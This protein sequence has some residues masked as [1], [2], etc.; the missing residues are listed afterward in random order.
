MYGRTNRLGDAFYGQITLNF[1]LIKPGTF[2]IRFHV[3]M[4]CSDA[5]GCDQAGDT[6]QVMVNNESPIGFQV[7]IDYDNIGQQRVWQKI[8]SLFTTSQNDLEV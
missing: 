7:N 5:S 1:D 6:I 2:E 8:S 4:Y 3:L